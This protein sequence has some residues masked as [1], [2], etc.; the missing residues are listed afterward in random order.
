MSMDRT[1][2][3]CECVRDWDWEVGGAGQGRAA[4]EKEEAWQGQLLYTPS[5]SSPPC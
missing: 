5:V 2:P 1:L 3:Y 4:S